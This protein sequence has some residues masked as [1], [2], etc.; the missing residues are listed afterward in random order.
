MLQDGINQVS[1]KDYHA[2]TRYFSSSSFK[3]LITDLAKFHKEKILGLKEEQKENPN[4]TEGSYVHSLLLE[5]EKVAEE[6]AF[7]DGWRKAGKEWEAFKA[8][9]ANKTILS[10][11]Q[12]H[13]CHQWVA[14]VE[15]RR[16]ALELL[17][18]GLPE[19]TICGKFMDVPVKVRCDYINID[20][21]Y[22]VDIKT[23]GY[24]ADTDIFKKT[25]RDF[26]YQLS[27]AMYCE[28]AR[29]F[30]NKDFAFYFVVISKPETV[31]DVYKLSKDSMNEGHVYLVHA[32][33]KYKKCLETNC[34]TEDEL[35][36]IIETGD[37]EIEEV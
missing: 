36:H 4:F 7:F 2:D 30:Y 18:G 32:V 8:V 12:A 23:T 27:A 22:I 31:C 3:L 6:Y 15:R 17:T 14:S 9:N 37:Y 20:K 16:E 5:P 11:P 28:V 1:N 33:N 13:R 21:G 26:Y 34:W 29:S 35:S 24:P 10:K 25:V 19:H